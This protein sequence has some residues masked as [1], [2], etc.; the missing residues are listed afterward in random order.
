MELPD[1]RPR[2]PVLADADKAVEL[3]HGPLRLDLAP[4]P[5]HAVES[6]D[7]V[8]DLRGVGVDPLR[9][10]AKL[11]N[12]AGVGRAV[13]DKHRGQAVE[14]HEH[15]LRPPTQLLDEELLG[16]HEGDD[17]GVEAPLLLDP[18]PI[19]AEA[20]RRNVFLSPERC[21]KG[22]GTVVD[23]RR[24][25]MELV[26]EEAADLEVREDRAAQAVLRGQLTQAKEALFVLEAQGSRPDGSREDPGVPAFEHSVDE[27]EIQEQHRDR[28]RRPGGPPMTEHPRRCLPGRG[29]GAFF[30]CRGESGGDHRKGRQ[31]EQGSAPHHQPAHHESGQSDEDVR[32]PPDTAVAPPV[33][34]RQHGDSEE[35][36]SGGKAISIGLMTLAHT[37]KGDA[38]ST[39]PRE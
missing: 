1:E 34:E 4:P 13:P 12:D 2:L 38:F 28:P 36:E 33:P 31:R 17:H 30:P 27:P 7:P 32:R 16:A 29:L 22:L 10:E 11:S 20:Q 25:G 35:R 39:R 6:V 5:R 3:L 15:P 23:V 21:R 18:G 14:V 24:L 26:L 9:A 19:L 8:A 37:S